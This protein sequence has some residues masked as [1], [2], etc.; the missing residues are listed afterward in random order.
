VT[1]AVEAMPDGGDLRIYSEFR[2]E[3]KRSLVSLSIS[4]TG[5]GITEE[6]LDR[7]QL[8]FVTTKPGGIGL[9]LPICRKIIEEHHGTLRI[10]SKLNHGTIV[11]IILPVH[12]TSEDRI[13]EETA[14]ERG[15]VLVA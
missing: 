6:D 2:Q 5:C 9:G 14:L 3:D 11:E 1:N 8:P 12:D 13:A 15:E 10:T 7:I 4:D